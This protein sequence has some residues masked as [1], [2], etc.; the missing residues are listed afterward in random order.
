MSIVRSSLSALLLRSPS[1]LKD[2]F[3][4]IPEVLMVDNPQL[5]AFAK[6]SHL[7]QGQDPFQMAVYIQWLV[8]EKFIKT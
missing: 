8:D 5:L 3:S 7:T 2:L 1:G 4:Q 6:A